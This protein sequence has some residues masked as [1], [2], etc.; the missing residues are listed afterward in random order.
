M[1]D[2]EPGE[3]ITFDYAMTEV[4]MKRMPCRCGS[5]GCRREISGNDWMDP[6]LQERYRGYFSTYIQRRIEELSVQSE[7]MFSTLIPGTMNA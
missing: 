7:V 3:E 4:S 6:V 2:I 5:I 1:R